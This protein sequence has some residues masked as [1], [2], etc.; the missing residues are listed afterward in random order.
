MD[1][2]VRALPRG[3]PLGRFE[4]CADNLSSGAFTGLC[5]L[6]RREEVPNIF[7]SCPGARMWRGLASRIR[8]S[9]H[10]WGVWAWRGLN[11]GTSSAPWTSGSF[12]SSLLWV[13]ACSWFDAQYEYSYLACFRA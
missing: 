12:L 6:A 5:I 10:A 7:A 4:H 2:D 13:E 11:N 1:L 3:S 9:R 8:A